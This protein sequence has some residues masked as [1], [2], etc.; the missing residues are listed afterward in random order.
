MKKILTGSIFALSLL[1]L[2]HAEDV[3]TL[4]ASN[5]NVTFS[6]KRHKSLVNNCRTCHE[7]GPGEIRGFGKETAHSSCIGCHAG[8][9]AGPTRCGECHK[10]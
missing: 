3:I 10:K 6:H 2:A 1:G 4:K 8:K 5:G 7:N 9:N